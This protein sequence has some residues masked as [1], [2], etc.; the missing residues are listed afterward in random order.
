MARENVRTQIICPKCKG[1]DIKLLEVS[2]EYRVWYQDGEG[3][4]GEEQEPEYG[5]LIAVRAVCQNADCKH[6]W[7][8]RGIT[9]ITELPNWPSETAETETAEVAEPEVAPAVVEPEPVVVPA[10]AADLEKAEGKKAGKRG[11]R[12]DKKAA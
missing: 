1:S 10:A 11:K 2:E 12:A 6:R 5:D 7:T 3:K 9:E 4:I 8:V